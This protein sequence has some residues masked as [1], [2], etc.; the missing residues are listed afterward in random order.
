MGFCQICGKHPNSRFV[1][2]PKEAF[3]FIWFPTKNNCKPNEMCWKYY[4]KF[5]LPENPLKYQRIFEYILLAALS[6]IIY[7]SLIF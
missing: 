3:M 4:K 1:T 5:V 2:I 7:I 6:N